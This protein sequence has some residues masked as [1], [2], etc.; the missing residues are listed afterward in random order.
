MVT[1]KRVSDVTIHL[2]LKFSEIAFKRKNI[3]AQE[4]GL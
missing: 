2:S 4:T 3:A 1:E